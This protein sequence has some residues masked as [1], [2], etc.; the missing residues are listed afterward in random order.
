VQTIKIILSSHC[1]DLD[2]GKWIFDKIVSEITTAYDEFKK[3]HYPM[4]LIHWTGYCPS[5]QSRKPVLPFGN[6]VATLSL[7]SIIPALRLLFHRVRLNLSDGC[8][9]GLN[10]NNKNL[11]NPSMRDGN[12]CLSD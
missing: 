7:I 10:M 4:Y 11:M 8:L 12:L 5:D 3:I 6:M 2:S 1:I 9:L